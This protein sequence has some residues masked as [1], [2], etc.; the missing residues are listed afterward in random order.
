MAYTE[1]QKREHIN[2]LQGYLHG[3]SYHNPN[4]PRIIPDGIYGQETADAVRAFQNAYGLTGSGEANHAT[5][6]KVVEVYRELVETIAEALQVFPPG[7]NVTVTTNDRGLAVLVIQAILQ[8][9]AEE[10]D[11]LPP[12][13]ITGVYD[14]DT[15]N[16]VREFQKLTTRPVT[17]SVDLSTWN[18]LASTAAAHRMQSTR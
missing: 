14:P 7:T 3:I 9:L 2:E 12:I 13:Q 15:V 1:A 18:L 17:G 4:I 10:Y 16:A 6:E 5:W 11:N 8:T